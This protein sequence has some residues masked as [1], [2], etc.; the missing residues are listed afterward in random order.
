ML[1]F[2][3]LRVLRELVE[4]QATMK[5][6]HHAAFERR[7]FKAL[8]LELVNVFDT[9]EAS[10]RRHGVD[11]LGGHSLGA[12]CERELGVTLDKSEQRSNW[13][14]RPLT[15]T[16]IEYAAADAQVLLALFAKLADGSSSTL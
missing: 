12:V 4:D 7:V 14:R 11:A 1:A 6:V 9:L 15:P 13:A 3:D 8:G 10:R 16:Q 5:I 2:E